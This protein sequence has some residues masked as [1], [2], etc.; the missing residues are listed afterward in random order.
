MNLFVTNIRNSVKEDA[1]KALFTE[2]GE[3]ASIKIMIDKFTGYSKGFGFV[4]MP[5]EGH[6]Y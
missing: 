5:D 4:E 1:Q 6:G 2:F 3:V